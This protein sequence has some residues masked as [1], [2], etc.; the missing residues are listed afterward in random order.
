MGLFTKNYIR[1][2]GFLVQNS[3]G[4]NDAELHDATLY[5]YSNGNC[6]VLRHLG[7]ERYAAHPSPS[8]PGTQAV[9]YDVISHRYKKF[10]V[11]E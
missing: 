2:D 10:I 7:G 6:V 4:Y 5:I 1:K 9:A 11:T 8:F 3:D